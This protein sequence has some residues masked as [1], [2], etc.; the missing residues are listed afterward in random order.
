[1]RDFKNLTDLN[2]SYNQL[3]GL[4]LTGLT[5]LKNLSY[6]DNL[7]EEFNFNSLNSEKLTS[8]NLKNNNLSGQSK[9][10]I[11]ISI[12]INFTKLKQLSIGND[13]KEKIEESKYNHFVGSLSALKGL[14]SLENLHISNTDI[15]KGDIKDIVEKIKEIYYSTAERPD[16]KL[17]DIKEKLDLCQK[18]IDNHNTKKQLDGNFSDKN[19][20]VLDIS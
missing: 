10:D 15:N 19:I 17:K 11:D 12:F 13:N 7:L 5:K 16:S 3:T 1:L 2:C 14:I 4:N 6:N 8:L 18:K 9:K 20:K